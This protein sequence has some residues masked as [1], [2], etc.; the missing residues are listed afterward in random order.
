MADTSFD[1]IIVGS[2]PGGY[3]AAIRAALL[4]LPCGRGVASGNE[5]GEGAMR[6]RVASNKRGYAKKLRHNLTDAERVL[7][8]LLRSR[9]LLHAKFR[10]QV[11]ISSWIV[12][13]VSFEH[14]LIVEADGSQHNENGRDAVR[15]LDLRRRGFQIL[16][17]WNNDILASRGPVLERVAE[18][19]EQS[20]S[21]GFAPDS[22]QPFSPTRA[23][24]R[25]RAS[26][27][28][29]GEGK[30]SSCHG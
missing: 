30:Q 12:D 5:P 26:A 23:C 1:I 4:T 15:D 14:R 2:G 27:A 28:R 20:P 3:I 18:M 22:A 11:P 13:F 29:V 17:F 6:H 16:H 7:W 25:A 24:A 21:P 9:R 10:R 8:R 19:I